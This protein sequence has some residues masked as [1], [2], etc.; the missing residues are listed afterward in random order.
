MSPL[1]PTRRRFIAIAAAVAATAVWPRAGAAAMALHEWRGVALGAAATIRLAH[2]DEAAARRLLDRCATEIVRLE[3]IFS[4]YRP[5]S[6]LCRLNVA[7]AL[8]L[9]PF[10]L[11]ELLGRAAAVSAATD[12]VFDATVQ[13]L[14]RLYAEHFSAADADPAGP[15][16]EAV[17]PLVGWRGVSVD[18]S[19]ITL[20]R[21]GMALTLNGI[22]QGYITDRV[23][24]LLRAEGMDHVL[25]D[26]GETR[27][28]GT[29]PDGRPWR[30]GL[31]DPADPARIAERL[32]L[33]DLALA[34]SGGYG[35]RFEPTG[36]HNHL[37]DPRSGRSA[38]A[39]RTVSVLARDAT[40]ADAAS[41]ALSF[42]PDGDAGPTL[43]R[44]G[45]I[46]AH[47]CGPDGNLHIR[48]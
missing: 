8:D 13:P 43:R 10:E 30:V 33:A 32:S 11:V 38:P 12:G 29:H 22:A 2:P 48:A 25:V 42:L 36:R 45:A 18:D 6:A 39:L 37:I 5:D 46:A 4:L 24:D 47:I 23:A 1:E 44:L 41:T 26:L 28:I 40:T 34:T 14:W 3:R 9:P 35:T 27:A 31:A 17:L 21:T 20:A 19:R 15:A 7:G 16:V